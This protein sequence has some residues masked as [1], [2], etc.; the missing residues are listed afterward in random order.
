MLEALTAFKA[1]PQ[2]KLQD[3]SVGSSPAQMARDQ[4]WIRAAAKAL[5]LPASANAVDVKKAF[6]KEFG[7]VGDPPSRKDLERLAEFS[8]RTSV[9]L[10]KTLKGDERVSVYLDIG[11]LR[12][13]VAIDKKTDAKRLEIMVKSTY[14]QFFKEAG[15]LQE[16]SPEDAGASEAQQDAN[17]RALAAV[18]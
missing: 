9:E 10:Q 18:N 17:T 4:D 11:G 16:T 2:T 15:L 1:T 3:G 13:E 14:M 8:A 7:E 5:H 6:E 12:F